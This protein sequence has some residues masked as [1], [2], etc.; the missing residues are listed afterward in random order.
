[1][2]MENSSYC[3]QQSGMQLLKSIENMLHNCNF[4]LLDLSLAKIGVMIRIRK[5][6]TKKV[7]NNLV[8]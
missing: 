8:L 7:H 3:Q 4:F 2:V 6:K 1:M 5:G